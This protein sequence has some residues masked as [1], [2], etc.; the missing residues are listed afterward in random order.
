MAV[1]TADEAAGT[2]Q[3]SNAF[4]LWLTGFEFENTIIVVTLSKLTMLTSTGK[5]TQSR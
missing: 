1:G 5:G 3:R 4:Q 2:Y